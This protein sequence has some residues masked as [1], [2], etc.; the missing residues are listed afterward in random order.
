MVQGSGGVDEVGAIAGDIDGVRPIREWFGR[1]RRAL[2]SRMQA[3][4]RRL[5]HDT[6]MY[7]FAVRRHRVVCREAERSCSHTFTRFE[8]LP[9]QLE[10]LVG[11]AL[12]FLGSGQI[13]QR[14]RLVVLAGSTG[15][16]AYTLS[17]ALLARYPELD[18]EV[19]ASD[20]HPELVELAQGGRYLKS[21]VYASGDVSEEFLAQTF[22]PGHGDTLVVR[23]EVRART[24]FEVADL[25]D[26]SLSRRFGPA[27]V[28]FAQNVFFHLPPHLAERAFRNV[29]RILAPR[30]CLFIDGMNLDM[31]MSLTREYDLTPL[32]DGY[33]EIYASARRHI[34]P[35]WWDYYYGCE[36]FRWTARDR[37]RR[38]STIFLRPS[39]DGRSSR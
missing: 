4:R 12:E 9:P 5:L 6:L 25:L 1:L 29:V 36:P 20:L 21:D 11:P 3:L 38:Y 32:E 18:F 7:P 17:S 35:R 13:P 10:A 16:E 26:E 34:P 8:R 24:S 14:V 22:E 28:V 23:P 27:D 15:A 33:R 2:G 31:K 19:V 30:A 37:V 39:G